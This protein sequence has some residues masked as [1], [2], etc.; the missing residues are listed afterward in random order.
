M[1]NDLPLVGE[2]ISGRYYSDL[3]DRVTVMHIAHQWYCIM[4]NIINNV[5]N[6]GEAALIIELDTSQFFGFQ[7][8]LLGVM[9]Y[10]IVQ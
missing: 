7:I 9:R 5:W 2:N 10:W 8:S 3:L 6:I 1:T 4:K